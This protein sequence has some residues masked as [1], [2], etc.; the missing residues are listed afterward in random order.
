[1]IRLYLCGTNYDGVWASDVMPEILKK[2]MTVGILPLSYDYGWS[3]DAVEWSDQFAEDGV[4][5]YDLYRPLISCGIPKKNIR[6]ID[7]FR[8]E[9]F[10]PDDYD[11]LILAGEDPGECMLRME[12]LGLDLHTYRGILIGLSA[13]A[14]I[15]AEYYCQDAP[16]LM[17]G[18]ALSHGF[19]A[20][21]HWQADEYHTGRA[22]RLLEAQ[23]TPIIC[24]PEDGGVLEE[25]GK[26]T[27]F[28]SASVLTDRDLDR[29]YLQ[30]ERFR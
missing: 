26:I 8:M 21:M 5:R 23:D 16:V 20:E 14:S 22:I 18:L 9:G 27:L 25:A 7:H 12:D 10:R 29:L 11:V 30:Y 13:G 4:F 17:P 24:I 19:L 1:M 2:D 28:G 15:M 3:S 6:L